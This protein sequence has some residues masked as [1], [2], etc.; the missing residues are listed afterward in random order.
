[1]SY[2]H[3][4]DLVPGRKERVCVVGAGMSGLVAMKELLAKG[5]E[6]TCYEQ[7][8]REGGVFTTGVAYSDMRLTVSQHYMCFTSMPPPA[9]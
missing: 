3:A 2:S 4:T 6:V 5:H 7:S 9:R 1:M 8:Q